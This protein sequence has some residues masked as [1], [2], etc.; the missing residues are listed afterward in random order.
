MPAETASAP[1]L[2]RGSS[3]EHRIEIGVPADFI[4]ELLEDVN[5]WSSWNPIYRAASGS[6]GIGD[7]IDMTV[8]LPGMKP[9]NVKAKVL[10]SIPKE[11][12]HY[13]S[14]ALGGLLRATRY[15]EIESPAPQSCIVT[16]GEVMSGLL[17]RLVAR[18]V[19]P[20]VREGL[21]QMNEGLKEAA[22]T[23]WREKRG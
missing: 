22:E 4:W 5:G 20:R 14:P 6:I 15:V 3:V 13:G 11:R 12:L 19:G 16:N 10:T 17:G 8:A 2:P 21:Q 7:S 1:S 18:G 23:K 9:Q